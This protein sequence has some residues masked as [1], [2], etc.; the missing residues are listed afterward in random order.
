MRLKPWPCRSVTQFIFLLGVFCV[1]VFCSP[2]QGSAQLSVGTF[3]RISSGPGGISPAGNAGAPIA[4]GNG[5]YIAFHST[6][7]QLVPSDQNFS[8]DVFIRDLQTDLTQRVSV[9]SSGIEGDG[10]SRNPA[11]SNVGPDGLFAVVFESDA[12]N[13]DSTLVDN[14]DFPDV[15]ISLPTLALTN[16]ISI[17]PAPN[18]SSDG[19]SFSPSVAFL[20]T[21][22]SLLVAFSSDAT[23][24][25]SDDTNFERDIYLAT[26]TYRDIEGLNPSAN[27]VIERVSVPFA[28]SVQ[29]PESD[30][31]SDTPQL[32]GNGKV[33][34]FTSRATNLTPE[35][36]PGFVQIYAYDIARGT[37]SLVSK[38]ATGLPGNGDSSSPTI[39]YNGRFV[40][41]V[42]E[43]TNI[44]D[45]VTA[46]RRHVIRYDF[47]ND[48]GELVSSTS[49]GVVGN[50]NAQDAQIGPTGRFVSFSD[51]SSNL[52]PSDN[53]N[54]LD[55]FVKDFESAELVRA[56][57]S[58]TGG[59]PD[60]AS[61]RGT[62]VADGFNAIQ[63]T[64]SFLSQANN[65]IENDL[66]SADVYSADVGIPLPAFRE[67][68]VI[69]VPPD[70]EVKRKRTL[71]S[72]QV[73]GSILTAAA[74]GSPQA[75]LGAARGDEQVRYQ[76]KIRGR[77]V[78]LT[79]RDK[80]AKRN[81]VSV[82]G[83]RPGSYTAR[84]R[85][86]TVKSGQIIKKTP[87]SPP[88]RFVR[89]PRS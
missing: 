14:N 23:N 76:Y 72:F 71:L 65:I 37:T 16:L 89:E 24:F 74:T 80:L 78:R 10:E 31:D 81:A 28:P 5:R 51:D 29:S 20:P 88:Q 66:T 52:V 25:I 86:V 32:S 53:N 82:R 50:G 59:D 34:V 87:Y 41:Y 60:G 40:S 8:R 4:S 48:I 58:F 62:L 77:G 36:N 68:T 39:S 64:V 22:K 6:D 79:N 75:L 67:D 73:F 43:A 15:Y 19:G 17:A 3:D 55:V 9:S 56:S 35:G 2:R 13:L 61:T 11:I 33:L 38:D 1:F 12:T 49:A 44:S 69:E 63:G 21:R 47:T 30:G 27:M 42:T 84:Y 85:A 7:A 70:I 18:F 57:V 46:G 83:L 45:A 54:N 26:I